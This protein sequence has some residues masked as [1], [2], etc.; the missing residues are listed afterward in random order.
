MRSRVI[1]PTTEQI[2]RFCAA[3]PVERVF[4]EDV[5]RRRRG[6][7]AALADREGELTALCHLGS[8]LVPSGVGCGAFAGLAVKAGARMLIGETGAVT[9]LWEA[10]RRK[11]PSPRLDRPGQP[12][13]AITEMP[14]EGGTNLRP[15]TPADLDLLVPACAAAH[16][17]EIAV[18]PLRHDPGG[19]RRRT[20]AQIDEGRSWLWVEDGVIRFKAEVSA[21]TDTAVQLQQV[22]ADPPARGQGYG[23]RALRDLIRILLVDTP[24]VCLFVRAENAVAILLYESVGMSH[25]LDYRSILL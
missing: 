11:L 24:I 4:L 17:E 20:M 13:Y 21:W 25:V 1:E 23:A 18:D 7:F 8:N 14:Q 16:F 6:R 22:W 5:A 10:V 19:F 9:D 15:A 3:E 2:L 12:V